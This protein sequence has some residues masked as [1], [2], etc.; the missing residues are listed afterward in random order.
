VAEQVT[1][2]GVDVDGHVRLLAAQRAAARDA[3]DVVSKRLRV[4]GITKGEER[5]QLGKRLVV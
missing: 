3:R 5:R 1:A 4:N 2:G